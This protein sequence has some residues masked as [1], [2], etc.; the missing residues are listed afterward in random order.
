MSLFVVRIYRYLAPP[1]RGMLHVTPLHSL[2]TLFVLYNYI[3]WI[4]L[5]EHCNHN[6]GFLRLYTNF[7]PSNCLP[8]ASNIVSIIGSLYFL[9]GQV[10]DSFLSV[11]IISRQSSRGLH[12]SEPFAKVSFDEVDGTLMQ[13]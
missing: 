6:H 1:Q 5:R 12:T 11:S 7:F 10:S 3:K 2:D 8:C 9:D 13:Y 4:Y